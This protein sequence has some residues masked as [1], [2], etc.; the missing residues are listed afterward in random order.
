RWFYQISSPWI[1]GFGVA[2]LVLLTVGVVWG[3]VYAP[4]DYQQGNSFRIMYVHV[5]AA[6]VSQ[7]VYLGM[8]VAGFVLFVWRMKLADVAIAA[9]LP[10]G[11]MLTALALFTG[12]VWGRPTWGTWWEWDG[13]TVSTLVL[14][15]LYIGIYALREAILDTELRGRA[16]ALVAM[17]GTI[18]IPIIKYSVDWWSTL[19]QPAS[20]TL[21]DKPTMPPEMWMPLLVMVLGIYCFA[22]HNIMSRM[23]VEILN[24]ESKT[25]WV[26]NLMVTDTKP[27][28]NV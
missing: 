8:G 1:I 2:A 18:N 14:L 15:F 17:V 24:R 25:R 12:G 21:T 23:R 6:M 4:Q 27:I 16:S 10:F 9:C 5:P 13:R 11:I 20:I 26:R 28:Q 3:L 22:A 19:H 7:S